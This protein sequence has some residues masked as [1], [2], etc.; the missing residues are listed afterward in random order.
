MKI[1][2]YMDRQSGPVIGSRLVYEYAIAE[3]EVDELKYRQGP[4]G[5]FLEGE[6]ERVHAHRAALVE[7]VAGNIARALTSGLYK[8]LDDRPETR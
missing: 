2:V 3:P 8:V 6:H 4:D 7:A 5:A 1:V